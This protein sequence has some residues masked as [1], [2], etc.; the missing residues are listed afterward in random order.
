MILKFGNDTR[1]IIL[2]FVK[3][4]FK[5]GKN[6]FLV[7]SPEREDP[8]RKNILSFN[9]QYTT[10]HVSGGADMLNKCVEIKE[11]LHSTTKLI[12]VTMLTSFNDKTIN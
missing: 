7:Y 6:F 3:K 11:D 8:G 12:G 2:P 9:P 5:I 4:K 10:L 1:E